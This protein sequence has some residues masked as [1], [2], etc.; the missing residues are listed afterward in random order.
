MRSFA[1][2]VAGL[3][4]FLVL[5][6]SAF[7]AT[8]YTYDELGRLATVTY[9]NG[10]RVTYSYDDAGNR[11]QVV[12]AQGSGAGPPVANPDTGTI[13]EGTVS[14]LFNPLPNDTG[15]GLTIFNVIGADLGNA[16][17]TNNGTRIT[18]A[19]ST[20]RPGQD[21]L[22]YVITDSQGVSATS[23]LTISLTNLPPVAV[24][25]PVSVARN[26][27]FTFN[28]LENDT[29]PGGDPLTI[30]A[31][32]NGGK[33]AVTINDGATTLT[34]SPAQNQTG[35]DSFTYTITDIDG[36]S[37]SGTVN[38][39][40][41]GS[42]TAPVAV[43]DS[44]LVLEFYTGTPVNASGSMNVVANDTDVDLDSL[45]IVSGSLSQ[46]TKGTA[47]SSNGKDVLY[48]YTAQTGIDQELHDSDSFTY[49]VSDG[50][51]GTSN[52]VTVSVTI[53]VNSNE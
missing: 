45:T 2:G 1:L 39:T 48:T 53:Q 27:P 20:A 10:Q 38:V 32:T 26:V 46:P 44:F 15:V 14:K 31:S 29:D 22:T 34:Y 36:A 18:Y 4:T 37:D 35:S 47:T 13:S 49:R 41:S 16:S 5:A 43:A 25:D 42:N 51:G 52:T 11:T 28:P 21:Q 33:G 30:T 3:A 50:Q 23:T 24:N 6:Q 9:D 19:P 8:T 17:V 12:A 40:I 7:A